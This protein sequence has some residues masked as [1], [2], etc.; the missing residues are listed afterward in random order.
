MDDVDDDQVLD[1]LMQIKM[2]L[3]IM[4]RWYVCE[5]A[6]QVIVMQVFQAMEL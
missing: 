2:F 4:V 1:I 6:H 3:V 5:R